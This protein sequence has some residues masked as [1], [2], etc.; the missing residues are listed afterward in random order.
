[1]QFSSPASK[2]NTLTLI[3]YGGNLNFFATKT[4]NL[5]LLIPNRVRATQ[6]CNI[7]PY[8]NVI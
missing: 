4:N 8:S 3:Q 6:V 1:M 5:T 7:C 2:Y